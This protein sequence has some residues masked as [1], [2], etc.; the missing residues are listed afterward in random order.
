MC[1]VAA[2]NPD[3]QVEGARPVASVC[4]R[5]SRA[6]AALLPGDGD[7]MFFD[8]EEVQ[9]GAQEAVRAA[10]LERLDE[11]LLNDPARFEDDDEEYEEE[12]EEEEVGNG[13]TIQQ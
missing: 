10:A 11:M 1:D 4:K 8:E 6:H 12:E 9:A 5:C 7:D 2:M 13:H 3:P